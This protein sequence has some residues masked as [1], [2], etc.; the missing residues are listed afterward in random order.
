MQWL[1]EHRSHI[2]NVLLF[3]LGWFAC[4][5]GGDR[6]AL[7]AALAIAVLHW[8]WVSR[9]LQQWMFIAMV[10][11]LGFVTDSM[12]AKFGVFYFVDPSLGLMPFWLLC[13]WLL[14]AMTFHHSMAWL[15]DRPWLSA[16]LGAWFGPVAYLS[17]SQ[18]AGVNF[19][20]PVSQ[21]LLILAVVWAAL[22]PSLFWLMRR[23]S[24]FQLQSC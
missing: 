20:E 23:F 14:F 13:I 22:L 19:P 9:S 8:L 24:C 12:L 16:V 3:Q 1:S 7:P 6:V 17:G 11:V 18:F 15:V 21:P 2:I 10:G 5:L 4:V